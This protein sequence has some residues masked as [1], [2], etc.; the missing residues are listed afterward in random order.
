MKRGAIC[1]SHGCSKLVSHYGFLDP[2]LCILF[3]DRVLSKNLCTFY[4][5]KKRPFP[6]YSPRKPTIRDSELVQ[7]ISS[8]IK[9]RRSET[10]GHVLKPFE[11][12]FR[13]EHIIWVLMNIKNDYNILLNFYKWV[14]LRREPSLEVRCIVIH[15]AVASKDSKTAHD[16]I[17]DFWVKPNLD[18]SDSFSYFVEKLIYTYKEWGSDPHVFDLFFEALVEVGLPAEARRF[19]G[20]MLNYGLLISADSCKMLLSHLSNDFNTK[21]AFKVFCEFLQSGVFWDV[22]S[23]NKIIHILCQLGKVRE[24][25]QLLLLMELRGCIPDAV[26]YSTVILSLIHI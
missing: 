17:Y 9:Q 6:D 16:L 5:T 3:K 18:V 14:C 8:T 22:E 25:H 15:A 19:F 12:E 21:E 24:A 11:S 2:F 23:Y 1:L 10:L 26:S 13:P 20:K 4:P 7:Y